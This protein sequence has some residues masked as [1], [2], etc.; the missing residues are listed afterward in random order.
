MARGASTPIAPLRC[1]VMDDSRFDRKFLRS[2]ANESR[3]DL[4]FIETSSIAETSEFLE[5]DVAD[6]ALLDYRVPDGDGI[7][8]ARKLTSG[9]CAMGMPIIVVTGDGSEAAA[10]Q[11]LRSGAVDY[12]NKNE[13]TT[14]SFDAAIENALTRVSRGDVPFVPG[15]DSLLDENRSLRR[16]AIRNM[17]LLKGQTMPLLSFAG[18]AVAKMTPE[19]DP[20]GGKSR[21]LAK[22]AR[23]VLG[24]VD[25][26]VIHAA[27]FRVGD[28]NEAVDLGAVIRDL[29]GDE[30]SEIFTSHA[31]VLVGDLPVL[32]ARRSQIIML[33]EE[34]LLN[35]IRSCEAGKVADISIKAS[36]DPDGNPI[37]VFEE[38]SAA[39]P[40]QKQR[41]K[42]KYEDLATPEVDPRV[43]PN[44]WSLCQRLV[45][46]NSG[47][48]RIAQKT[49]DRTRIMMRFP[50]HMIA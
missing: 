42:E 2:V 18:S 8:F 36:R 45:E 5:N 17:R 3:F 15:V 50:K 35:G 37:V 27:T 47:N 49:P 28:E 29:I 26:T 30:K 10:V 33:F 21:R 44:T 16:I 32:I 38:K 13:I 34:L 12:L 23:N 39:L 20:D 11:A 7:D 14:E 31:H 46:K 19:D 24:L 4:D 22:I 9:G 48:F 1:V 40:T 43:D 6:L 25:D 41:L